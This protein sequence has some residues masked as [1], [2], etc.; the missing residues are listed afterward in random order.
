MPT[1]SDS[2]SDSLRVGEE[3]LREW[4]AGMFVPWAEGPRDCPG[5]KFSQVEF[6]AVMAVLFRNH[7]VWPV[8]RE[9]QSVEDGKKELMRMANDSAVNLM[10]QMRNP[11]SVSLRWVK[12]SDD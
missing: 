12:K 8:L 3:M 5:K 7:R 6:V 9:G 10:M 4:Q 11:K 1:D 2:D